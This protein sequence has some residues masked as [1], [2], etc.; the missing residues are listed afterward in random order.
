M[1]IFSIHNAKDLG[2]A[3]RDRRVA[4]GLDQA[5]LANRVGVSRAWIIDIEKGKPRASVELVLRTL[6]ILG[7]QFITN[8]VSSDTTTDID[9]VFANLKNRRS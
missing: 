9:T 2:A 1:A 6:H 3:I 7:V 4:L 5:E 8:T